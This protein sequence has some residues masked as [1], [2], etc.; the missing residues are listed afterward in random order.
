MKPRPR[1]EGER[2]F[3]AEHLRGQ[4]RILLS[5]RP[6]LW[7]ILLLPFSGLLALLL[8][9]IGALAMP[10]RLAGFAVL[11]VSRGL[12]V[13]G[14]LGFVLTLVWQVLA[15]WARLYVIT[16][17]SIW[18]RSGVL[19]RAVFEVPREQVQQVT[20]VRLLLE[21]LVDVGSVLIETAGSGVGSVVLVELDDA[22]GLRRIISRRAREHRTLRLARV[23]PPAAPVD[24]RLP[25]IGIAGGIGSGKSAVAAAFAR[26]GCAVVD[27]DQEAR[28]A[29]DRPDV[30]A[31]L[32]SWWGDGVL[33]RDGA[34]D[35]KAVANIVF[36]DPAQ[37]ARL[38]ALVHPIV[39]QRRAQFAA[40]ATAESA[41]AVIVDAPLLFEAGV[42]AECDAV[43]FVE[44]PREIRLERLA[45][46][47]GWD[48]DEL[49]RREA[50]QWPLEQKRARSQFVI[51]N[52]GAP[53]AL[54]AEVERVLA[55]IARKPGS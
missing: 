15:W 23:Q 26:R 24:R 41:R 31:T 34:I 25:M 2:E 38:E 39:R 10:D 28:A 3:A 18:V 5:L 4:E 13:I 51:N 8:V 14:A 47:R 27:S 16:D 12:F 53:G 35:R 54:D 32:R 42:D 11:G 33:T 7:S 52:A 36:A 30:Q 1:A 19:D 40:H 46:T 49:A 22:A 50:A 21:R 55:A 6:S 29:L 44:V 48:S 43:V 9:M 20:I 45:R 17:R 37:R